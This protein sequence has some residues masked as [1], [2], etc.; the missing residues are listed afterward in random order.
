MFA[1]PAVSTAVAAAATRP[2]AAAACFCAAFAAVPEG[3]GLPLPGDDGPASAEGAADAGAE[4]PEEAVGWPGEVGLG[5]D[6][7]APAVGLA[8]DAL[9]VGVGEGGPGMQTMPRMHPWPASGAAMRVPRSRHADQGSR[10]HDRQRRDREQ[11]SHEAA[12]DSL[13]ASSPGPG[14]APA[15]SAAIGD[16]AYPS[17]PPTMASSMPRKKPPRLEAGKDAMPRTIP[18]IP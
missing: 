11:S 9:G 14:C 16:Q 15:P 8:D 3:D 17:A 2:G 4:D 13:P 7:G 10:Q 1:V 5:E 12:A 6:D 18:A